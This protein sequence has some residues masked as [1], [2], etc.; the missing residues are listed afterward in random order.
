M[1]FASTPMLEASIS[2]VNVDD[3]RFPPP[4][5]SSLSSLSSPTSSHHNM[6]SAA[7]ATTS[8]MTPEQ[9]ANKILKTFQLKILRATSSDS[10]NELISELNRTLQH[11]FNAQMNELREQLTGAVDIAKMKLAFGTWSRQVSFRSQRTTAQIG[12][13]FYQQVLAELTDSLVDD[14]E[15]SNNEA[16]Q[17][18]V[19]KL[20]SFFSDAQQYQSYA[21]SFEEFQQVLFT[22]DTSLS[23]SDMVFRTMDWA[24]ELFKVPVDATTTT[25]TTTATTTT[26]TRT[27]IVP[28]TTATSDPQSNGTL[29]SPAKSQTVMVID[30]A[31]D[32]E[33]PKAE[34]DTENH[35]QLQQ[36]WPNDWTTAGSRL[37]HTWKNQRTYEITRPEEQKWRTNYKCTVDQNCQARIHIH[38]KTKPDP[39]MDGQVVWDEAKLGQPGQV[40]FQSSHN[41]AP[42]N[43]AET[44][45]KGLSNH[46]DLAMRFATVAGGSQ[47]PAKIVRS[48]QQ[49]VPDFTS[50]TAKSVANAVNY[51]AI[52][53]GGNQSDVLRRIGKEFGVEGSNHFLQVESTKRFRCPLSLFI[54]YFK[55]FS[56]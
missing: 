17:I 49:S 19:S 6:R 21:R 37:G 55:L 35:E 39:K 56:K 15:Q 50:V 54:V 7:T 38:S 10:F 30:D 16:W 23:V 48:L 32:D 34:L 2:S 8:V 18:F 4:P 25:T 27:T 45:G 3:V 52:K 22:D 12:E 5:L 42:P 20:G 53:R 33:Q 1:S 41:H 26:T 24:S 28:T 31:I 47:S 9:V 46:R 43:P 11:L 13:Q 29:A 14:D 40:V 44:H 51:D 36:E